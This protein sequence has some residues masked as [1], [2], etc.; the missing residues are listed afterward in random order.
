MRSNFIAYKIDCTPYAFKRKGSS[1]VEQSHSSIVGYLG[2]DFT[3]ELPELLSALLKRHDF[4][5]NKTN[6]STSREAC[7]INVL[8]YTMKSEVMD[9]NIIAAFNCLTPVAFNIFKKF[10]QDS[11]LN[12]AEELPDV[13]CLLFYSG[14][15]DRSEKRLSQTKRKIYKCNVR[16]SN[17][18]QCIH[19]WILKPQFFASRWALHHH[20]R[21]NITKVLFAGNYNN[22]ILKNAIEP[23]NTC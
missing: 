11:I 2:K 16:I 1:P 21:Y 18:I 14:D 23:T 3:R 17:Q 7:D 15:C 13:T 6:E 10:M 9:E 20:R 22:P 8:Y 12:E 5:N 4:K 19:E